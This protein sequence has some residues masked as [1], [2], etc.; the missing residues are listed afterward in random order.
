MRTLLVALLLGGLVSVSMQA[1]YVDTRRLI[2]VSGEASAS[3]VPDHAVVSIGVETSGLDIAK[4]KASNDQKVRALLDGVKGLGIPAKDVQT[5]RLSIDPVYDYS[6]GKQELLRYRMINIVTIVVKDLSKVEHVVNVGV[7]SGSNMLQGLAFRSSKEQSLR[8]SLRIAAVVNAKTR[9]TALV[10]A[11][12]SQLGKVVTINQVA[13]H[14]RE[15]NTYMMAKSSRAD[16]GGTPIEAGELEITER[17][18][19]TFYVEG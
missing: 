1:Q 19:V 8:D 18:D 4:L 17:V 13:N 11:V 5:S 16:E 10:E 6:N 3:V 15:Y 2:N 12:G 7:A 9:A 14:Q